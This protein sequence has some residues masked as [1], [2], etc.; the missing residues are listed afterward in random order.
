MVMS[1]ETTEIVKDEILFIGLRQ[2]W[3]PLKRNTIQ[4]S[5]Q[6]QVNDNFLKPITIGATKR[7]PF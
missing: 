2:N 6:E 5:S 1:L 3:L 7:I 4:F